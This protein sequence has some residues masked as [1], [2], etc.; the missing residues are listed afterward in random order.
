MTQ[1]LRP[2]GAI[3]ASLALTLVA[4]SVTF[5]APLFY[6]K[7]IHTLP[8]N[9]S[10]TAI[11]SS[12]A[13]QQPPTPTQ[14]E[15]GTG[16]AQSTATATVPQQ[17]NTT[18][19]EECQKRAV[20]I[21]T[22]MNR[23]DTRAKNQIALF[24]TIATHVETFYANRTDSVSSYSQ[25]VSIVNADE[26]RA[27][28]DLSALATDGIFSC[29]GNNPSGVLSTYRSDLSTMETDIQDLRS[30]VKNLVVAIARGEGYT[31]KPSSMPKGGEQ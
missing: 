27:D 10:G 2:I 7:S 26:T 6:G 29:D 9:S 30:A 11:D 16:N 4:S 13:A 21:Q 24:T 28:S 1:R 31:L 17:L 14:H 20:V 22:I 5:A 8:I 18:Q 15:I 3:G 19:V 23:A 25:L 12:V